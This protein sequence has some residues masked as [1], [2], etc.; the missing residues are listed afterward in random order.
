MGLGLG[1][2]LRREAQW[3]TSG[4]VGD[5]DVRGKKCGESATGLADKKVTLVWP[6]RTTMRGGTDSLR[7]NRLSQ[8][9]PVCCCTSGVKPD[10]RLDGGRANKR[11]GTCGGKRFKATNVHKIS[12]D[13]TGR[14]GQSTG[15]EGMS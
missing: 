9:T 12:H 2:Y 7:R 13:K 5:N 8:P 15:K 14:K 3:R 4:C 10:L 1:E 11:E 6:G